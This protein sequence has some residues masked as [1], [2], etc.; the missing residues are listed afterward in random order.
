MFSFIVAS[1]STRRSSC[2]LRH[3]SGSP[4]FAPVF[5][6]QYTIGID[7]I[8][9]AK[10]PESRDMLKGMRTLATRLF[11]HIN[12]GDDSDDDDDDDNNF[13]FPPLTG[14][15][16]VVGDRDFSYTVSLAYRNQTTGNAKITASSLDTKDYIEETYSKGKANLDSLDLDSN[17]QL[18]H[19]LD[20]TEF[21]SLGNEQVWDSIVWNF[22]Y[23][24]NTPLAYHLKREALMTGF[25]QNM[26][27]ILKPYGFIYITLCDQ[28]G[29]DSQ[30]DLEGFAWNNKL[31]VTEV[32]SFCDFN[33]TG[34]ID[35][36]TYVLRH[37]NDS[38]LKLK[39]KYFLEL[40]KLAPIQR[41]IYETCF[42][43]GQALQ[44]FEKEGN[45]LSNQLFEF[46]GKKFG[47]IQTPQIDTFKELFSVMNSEL[48]NSLN[49]L[50]YEGHFTVEEVHT[51]L[52]EEGE[53]PLENFNTIY[54]GRFGKSPM[55]TPDKLVDSLKILSKIGTFYLIE[56]STEEKY[57]YVLTS[58]SCTA[59]KVQ[60]LPE[61]ET[62]TKLAA[63]AFSVEYGIC[64][65]LKESDNGEIHLGGFWFKFK[66]KYGRPPFPEGVKL[67]DELVRL[68]HSGKFQ[69]ETRR[70]GL[71]IT[72]PTNAK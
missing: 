7:K 48:T 21:G 4:P 38:E 67:K 10:F 70:G 57:Q 14:N 41:E 50:S 69:L 35:C 9:R 46:Y 30:W 8:D 66:Q 29:D 31:A 17:I 18:K 45:I 27:Q 2:I 56:Q 53:I 54:T 16:L 72:L 47:S 26:S 37:Q 55:Y 44:Q 71:W 25:F 43:P 51:L 23:S 32:S 63:G 65:L 34:D 24:P 28:H 68:S 22:P 58:K 33:I 15:I 3:L 12:T 49:L 59:D 62:A 42:T 60:K 19:E 6:R 39:D 11:S 20:I 36:L 1:G 52:E 61:K 40:E 64:E 13:R 5:K